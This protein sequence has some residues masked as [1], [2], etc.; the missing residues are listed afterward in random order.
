MSSK[1]P[2]SVRSSIFGDEYLEDED[3]FGQ[4][5]SSIDKTP[6]KGIKSGEEDANE[7]E[8]KGAKMKALD[9]LTIY[10]G[11][12]GADEQAG[13]SS[14]NFMEQRMHD[15]MQMRA[16]KRAKSGS[17]GGMGGMKMPSMGG[18]GG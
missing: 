6:A 13:L 15:L 16:M 12:D 18:M 17:G 14:D 5:D 11:G 1:I 7:V 4:Y 10:L 8:D 9:S 2:K 3:G